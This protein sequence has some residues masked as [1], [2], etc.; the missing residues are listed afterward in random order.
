MAN[1]EVRVYFC[2]ECKSTDVR[3]VFGLMNLFGTIPT[4][5][6]KKCNLRS[7]TF[8]ILIAKKAVLEQREEEKK[9]LAKKRAAKKKGKKKSVKKIPKRRVVKGVKKRSKK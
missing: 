7:S 8:P 6:C 3:Y 9:T 1:E 2:P 5:E 4:Q